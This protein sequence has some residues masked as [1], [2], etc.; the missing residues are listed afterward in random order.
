M[1]GFKSKA[2]WRPPFVWFRKR[3]R[4]KAVQEECH[5]APK[6][7]WIVEFDGIDCLPAN[8]PSIVRTVSMATAVLDS[9]D[10]HADEELLLDWRGPAAVQPQGTLGFKQVKLRA[11]DAVKAIVPK[12]MQVQ[13]RNEKRKADV[14]R[15]CENVV[16]VSLS[17]DEEPVEARKKSSPP[18]ST[19]SAKHAGPVRYTLPTAFLC[20]FFLRSP[21][22]CFSSSLERFNFR[23]AGDT[24]KLGPS[25]FVRVIRERLLCF[26]CSPAYFLHCSVLLRSNRI[27]LFIFFVSWQFEKLPRTDFYLDCRN[28]LSM[29]D[30]LVFGQLAS[31]SDVHPV[32]FTSLAIFLFA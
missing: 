22:C 21:L 14:Y 26:D 9:D 28:H 27:V 20:S 6:Q 12:P 24:P 31:S 29:S 10:D 4:K 25:I 30:S 16:F 7:R 15:S 17:D 8:D 13:E 19:S 1:F 23:I 32:F 5:G 11:A 18:F 2:T 3:R